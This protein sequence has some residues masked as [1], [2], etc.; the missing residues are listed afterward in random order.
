MIPEKF[1]TFS[2][3]IIWGLGNKN[4]ERVSLKPFEKDTVVFDRIQFIKLFLNVE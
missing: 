3:Y 2:S 1:G 4:G